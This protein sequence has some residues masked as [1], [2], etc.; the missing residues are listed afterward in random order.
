[1]GGPAMIAGGGLGDVDPDEVGPI[2]VQSANGVVDLAVADEAEA[3][4]ATKKLLAYFQG[5]TAPGPEPDQARLRE[6]V[7]ER[8]RRAYDPR[9][10]VETLCDEGA[11]PSC[12]SASR[13]RW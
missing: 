8:K 3:T 10:I 5:P 7:P 13:R 1:M 2:E 4:A 12:A 9:P 11:S 6:I